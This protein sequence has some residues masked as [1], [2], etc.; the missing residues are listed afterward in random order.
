[1]ECQKCGAELPEGRLYCEKCGEEV[2]MV[3]DFEPELE[4]SL[5][6]VLSGLANDLFENKSKNNTER[7]EK[8]KRGYGK[9]RIFFVLFLIGLLVLQ[10]ILVVINSSGYQSRQ[11]VLAMEEGQY[12]KAAEVYGQLRK[13][14]PEKLT[15][16]LQETQCLLAAA[17]KGKAEEVLLLGISK[18]PEEEELYT[19]LIALYEQQFRFQRISNLL[20]TCPNEAIVKKFEAYVAREP[21]FSQESGRYT[22]ILDLKLHGKKEGTIYYTMDG[23]EPTADS[24]VYT[25]PLRLGKGEHTIRALFVSKEG[26]YSDIAEAEYT[27]DVDTPLAP[28]VPLESGTYEEPMIIEVTAEEGTR[29]YYT[30]DETEPTSKSRQYKRPIPMPLGEST[31]RFVAYTEDGVPGKVTYR[32]YM[33]NIKTG[34][35]P[36]EAE[37]SLVQAQIGAGVLLDRNG[38]LPD[39]YGVYRYFYDFP[40]RVEENNYYIFSEHYLE[41]EINDL[42][43]R[44]FAVN[45]VSGDIYGAALE[46]DGSCTLK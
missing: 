27:I 39:R 35:S 37:S 25:A 31:F 7:P 38:A 6:D 9:R 19:Q 22:R 11:A 26:A 18:L 45:V 1:M 16:Y 32:R 24:R 15:W 13:K 12:E 44:Y 3:P 40:A 23:S 14:N 17:D 21:E 10:G 4:N 28:V 33:L 41:N 34:I 43:G 5:M 30:M 20:K 46:K 29:I 42:T 36:E 2:Q 8:R